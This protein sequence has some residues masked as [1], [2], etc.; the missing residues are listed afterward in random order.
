MRHLLSFIAFLLASALAVSCIERPD[1]VLDEPEMV[2]LLVDV[3]RAEGLFELQAD[4][5]QQHPDANDQYQREVIATVLLQHG[6]TRQ[7]YDSSLM[8]YAKHLT[9]FTRVYG[10]VEERLEAE[11]EQWSQQ[12][13]EAKDFGTSAAGDS[14]ELWA[15][16]NHLVLDPRRHTTF[17]T[18]T[19]PSDSNFV[20]GDT[21]HWQFVV[22]HL[23]PTQRL[24]VSA[25]LTRPVPDQSSQRWRL[26]SS[27]TTDQNKPEIPLGHVQQVLMAEG[28]YHF[29][30]RCDS[31]QPFGTARLV[32]AVA[33]DSAHTSPVI[34]D[35]ISLIRCHPAG[36]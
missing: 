20:A 36:Q 29:A 2:D 13:A 19:V 3:H 30:L 16:G 11:Q 14:V 35:S 33:L 1:C 10:H 26:R 12:I 31:L 18:W 34:I 5:E 15:I 6:V 28:R 21:L 23:L 22:R 7:Q 32:L 17:R 27:T 8:W 25:S 4:R 9:K 24:V